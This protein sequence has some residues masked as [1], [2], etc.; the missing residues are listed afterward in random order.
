ML[1]NYLVS[2]AA[3]TMAI[4]KQTR[5]IYRAAV[6]KLLAVVYVADI[7]A[8]RGWVHVILI[9]FGALGPLWTWLI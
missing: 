3:A 5:Q 7:V 6:S 2:A 4:T 1:I 9:G 8:L